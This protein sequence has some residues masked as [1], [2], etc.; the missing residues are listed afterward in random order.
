[1]SADLPGRV[2]QGIPGEGAE[3]LE[4]ADPERPPRPS[5]L[6]GTNPS[7]DPK[8]PLTEHGFLAF[9]YVTSA[10]PRVALWF[11]ACSKGEEL[12]AQAKSPV[13]GPAAG[14]RTFLK[15]DF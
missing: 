10:D 1:M 2:T 9:A 13:Q 7:M 15:I 4:E 14:N 12:G 5:T 3:L 11:G 8:T 6:P